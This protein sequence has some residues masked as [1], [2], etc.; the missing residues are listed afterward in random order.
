M[1][2][3][4]QCKCETEGCEHTAPPGG[5]SS[6]TSPAVLQL[7]QEIAALRA[8]VDE[9]DASGAGVL[10]SLLHRQ[11]VAH[12]ECGAPHRARSCWEAARAACGETAP[13]Q[14]RAAITADLGRLLLALGDSSAAE[15]LDE[16]I[17]LLRGEAS[18]E[19][20]LAMALASRA[21]AARHEGD[22]DQAIASLSEAASLLERR[23]EQ[24]RS[25]RD[26]TTLT[27]A[28]LDLGRAQMSAGRTLAARA[29]FAD[30]VELSAL[31]RDT[32]PSRTARNLLNA[33]LNHLG[34]AEE[35]LGQ[36][37]RA[38]SLFE[39]SAADM[40]RLVSEGRGDLADDLAQAEADLARVRAAVTMH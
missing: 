6:V 38:L 25:P 7:E 27:H 21:G 36:P 30:A 19:G 12:L 39:R 23:L 32:D 3:R 28:L 29:S 15:A 1:S 35:E 11:G 17:G 34:R 16:A 20:A 24:T 9:G 18:Q 2:E 26:A 8:R 14:Q 13:V 31:L 10:A 37:E 33:A 5:D 40:R 4:N 22:L